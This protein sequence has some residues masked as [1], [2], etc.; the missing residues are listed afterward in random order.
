MGVTFSFPMRQRSLSEATPMIM[1]K[2]FHVD[3]NEDLARCLSDGYA[4]AVAQLGSAAKHDGFPALR[5]VAILNDAVSTLVSFMYQF[6]EGEQRHRPDQGDRTPPQG[7]RKRPAMGLIVGTGCN[8]TIPLDRRL[9][10]RKCDPTGDGRVVVNTEWTLGGCASPLRD[11]GLVTRWDEVL[12]AQNEIPGYQPMEY[13]TAGRYLGEVARL[14]LV[15]YLTS[16]M[17]VGEETLPERLRRRH[18]LTTTFISPFRPDAGDGSVARLVES[19]EAEFPSST[20][21]V[22]FRWTEEGARALYAIAK[23]VQ[24]R[25]AGIVAAATVAL[26]RLGGHLE[27]PG[28]SEG[29]N[30]HS[31]GDIDDKAVNGDGQDAWGEPVVGYTGGCIVHFLDYLADCQAFLDK[32]VGWQADSESVR[33]RV[34]MSPCHDG[35]LEGAGVLAAGALMLERN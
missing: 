2:G 16:V 24:T 1:G 3:D 30:G 5:I 35:G 11:L 9:L 8:A 28:T 34:W 12:D 20:G 14:A 33:A 19:L 26:L 25:G 32:L 18:G 21:S 31:R 23:A 6:R 13:L 27:E 4:S 29:P 17:G 10:G 7:G 22:G 15:D